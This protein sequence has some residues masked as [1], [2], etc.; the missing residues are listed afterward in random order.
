MKAAEHQHAEHVEGVQANFRRE[1]EAAT[2]RI[3]VKFPFK[4]FRF[5]S[6]LRVD[7]DDDFHE[8]DLIQRNWKP[9]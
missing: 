3:S 5:K 1:V 2:K 9:N 4:F 7:R 8:L 6:S